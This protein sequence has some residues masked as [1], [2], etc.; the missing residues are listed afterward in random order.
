MPA[1]AGVGLQNTAARLA[2]LYGPAHVLALRPAPEGGT[3]A[4][5]RLPFHT[6][7]VSGPAAGGLVPPDALPGDRMDGHRTIGRVGREV[8]GV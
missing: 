8:A 7:P 4:E 2:Q 3:V 6:R 5:V 1:G